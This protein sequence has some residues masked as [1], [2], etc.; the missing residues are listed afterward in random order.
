MVLY[1]GT[2][3]GYIIPQ[4]KIEESVSQQTKQHHYWID[5]MADAALC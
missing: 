4:R 3:L 1:Y 2:K 5:S